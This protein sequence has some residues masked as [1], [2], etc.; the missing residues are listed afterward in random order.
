MREKEGNFMV[1]EKCH[2]FTPTHIVKKMLDEVGYTGNLYGKKFLENSCGD[3]HIL[4]EAVKRYIEDCK[5][6]CIT[7][8][9]I[10]SGLKH[11]FCAVE[12]DEK[13]F[14]ACKKNLDLVAEAYG[15]NGV[16]WNI[17]NDDFLSLEI[18]SSFDFIVGNPP[19]I[20]Y[21]NI[22]TKNRRFIRQNFDSCRKGKFDYCYP[23]I[24]LSLKYLRQNGKMA[25]LIPT[26]IFKNV[27][28]KDLRNILLDKIIKIFD[29]TTEKIFK[30]VLTSSA[31]IVCE[32]ANKYPSIKYYDISN[33]RTS[34]INKTNLN[35]KWVFNYTYNEGKVLFSEYFLAATSV[36]TLLNEA[37]LLKNYDETNEYFL[38]DNIPIEKALVKV[39]AGPRSLSRNVS[40]LIIFPYKFGNTELIKIETETMYKQYPGIIKHLEKF[41]DKLESRDSDKSS[42]WFEYGRSQ[43]I[44]N[45]NQRKLLM[46][47]IVTNRVNVYEL[48]ENTIPYSGIYI[49][50]KSNLDLS[51][52]K[53]ILESNEFL[54]YV[55]R[56]GTYVSGSSLRITAN[57]IKKFDISNWRIK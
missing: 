4:C 54:D 31:I 22:D 7:D 41:R 43:A 56:I 52:A 32:S 55:K 11:D 9:D 47:F 29:Y 8:G 19:Y 44:D 5:K 57:D 14:I 24:E 38:V 51:L 15:L 1:N 46:S 40:E 28:A 18:K 39:A 17:V 42:R 50:P 48:D 27:F 12:Y 20:S 21:S 53:K 34:L 33:K 16:E 37:F 13:N 49:V 25:Y 45:L 6:Y 3:G 10:I 26:N 23:F 35:D 30:N 2:V 36:A